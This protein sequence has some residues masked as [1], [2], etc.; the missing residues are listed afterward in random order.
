M[1]SSVENKSLSPSVGLCIFFS[2]INISYKISLANLIA[3]GLGLATHQDEGAASLI[4]PGTNL[5]TKYQ[6]RKLINLNWSWKSEIEIHAQTRNRS[7]HLQKI[8][9]TSPPEFFNSGIDDRGKVCTYFTL[10]Y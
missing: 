5:T 2:F 6:I 3:T 10:P 4:G 8:K 1:C 9:K 7:F